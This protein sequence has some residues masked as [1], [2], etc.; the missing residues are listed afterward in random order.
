MSNIITATY[1]PGVTLAVTTPLWQYDYGQIL[2]ISGLDLPDIYQVHFCNKGDATT[3]TMLGNADGVSIPDKVLATG[4]PIFAYI[5]LHAGEDD[6]ETVYKVTIP[7]NER[8]IP[9]DEVPTPAQRSALDE[10]IAALQTV[11]NPHFALDSNGILSIEG[12]ST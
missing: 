3:I 4:L 8:P 12:G 1:K 10:A 7:V 11:T 5:F 2:Q 6:G 9:A